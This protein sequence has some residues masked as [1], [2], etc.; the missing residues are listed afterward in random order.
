[1]SSIPR[2]IKKYGNRKLYDLD[3]GRYLSMFELSELVAGGARVEV[4]CDRTG[5]DV[6]FEALSR[7]LYERLKCRSG[8]DDDLNRGSAR[9]SFMVRFE[10]L[11]SDVECDAEPAPRKKKTK[12]KGK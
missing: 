6:T 8:I 1:M 2:K 12:G 10:S 3:G 4:T 11:I 5:L 9:E 7:A